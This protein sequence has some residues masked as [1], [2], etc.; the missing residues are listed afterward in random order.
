[1]KRLTDTL[2]ELF[3]CSE[4]SIP[5]PLSRLSY[6][7]D[8]SVWIM[9]F[10]QTR[11]FT[12]QEWDVLDL[13]YRLCEKLTISVCADRIPAAKNEISGGPGVFYFGRQTIFHLLE[14]FPRRFLCEITKMQQR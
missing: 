13:I 6:M 1:M 5:W 9:G 3:L 11:D 12:P 10:A 2:Q 4:N 14:R 8:T 7:K